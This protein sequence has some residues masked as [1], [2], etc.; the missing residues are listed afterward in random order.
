[1]NERLSIRSENTV[2]CVVSDVNLV[3][4]MLATRK[5]LIKHALSILPNNSIF[6]TQLFYT[7][8]WSPAPAL[9]LDTVTALFTLEIWPQFV[10]D[11]LG[12]AVRE[13]Q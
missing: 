6:F 1:M 9:P 5:P 10:R 8:P 2:I 11:P 7:W 3:L 12:E 4:L 13:Y